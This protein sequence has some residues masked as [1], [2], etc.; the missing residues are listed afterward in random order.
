ML[1]IVTEICNSCSSGRP[2][3]VANCSVVNI[4]YDMVAIDCAEG[5]NGGLVQVFQAEVYTSDYQHH[6]R[7][8]QSG[9]VAHSACHPGDLSLSVIVE[10]I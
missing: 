9:L 3:P 6:I 4:T 7:T 5:F 8:V 1:D 2:D 10:L